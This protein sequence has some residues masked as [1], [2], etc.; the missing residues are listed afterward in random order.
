MISPLLIP[1]NGSSID[2]QG[3]RG[4]FWMAKNFPYSTRTFLADAFK[5]RN[6]GPSRNIIQLRNVVGRCFGWFN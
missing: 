1:G 3:S 4:R 6:Q 5:G 2:R